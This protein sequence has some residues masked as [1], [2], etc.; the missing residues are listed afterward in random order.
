M[1]ATTLCQNCGE[2]VPIPVGYNRPRM[3][4]PVCGV[5]GDV[6]VPA[7][8]DVLVEPYEEAPICPEC[9]GRMQSAVGKSPH[10]RRCSATKIR[11]GV[12]SPKAISAKPLPPLPTPDPL[13]LDEELRHEPLLKGTD[14]D[15]GKPYQVP[16]DPDRKIPCPSCKKP[17]PLGTV[18]CN[19]C[20]FN[21]HTG[22]TIERTHEPV[23]KEWETGLAYQTRISIFLGLA[24]T[25]LV[26]AVIASIGTDE[27]LGM[28]GAWMT[29]TA[30]LAFVVGSYSR[31]NLT[32]NL[33]GKIRL[34]KSW[35]ICFIPQAASTIKW[36]QYEGVAIS[37]NHEN[38]LWDWLTLIFFFMA[39][40]IPAILWWL[41]VMEPDEFDV[42]LTR[43]HGCPALVLYRGRSEAM[44]KEIATCIR[45]ITGLN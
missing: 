5:I 22:E 17:V 44:A 27:W 35:R 40:V 42:A 45:N 16:A 13:P 12:V 1:S 21:R 6:S 37:R 10:C 7:E 25:A 19:H 38:G 15:D 3:R 24:G 28:A 33:R 34:T 36:R 8:E 39:G 4:C 11:E 29:G 14:E 32:R 26:A 43:D 23:A 41:Y 9:G 30:L 31:V 2:R 18:V 20:G